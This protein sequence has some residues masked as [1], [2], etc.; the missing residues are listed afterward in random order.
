MTVP[1]GSSVKPRALVVVHSWH[2]GNT[3]KVAEALARVLGAEVRT[4]DRVDPESL[5][6]YDLVGF[7]AGIDSG[8]HYRPILDLADKL[9]EGAG[10]RAFIFSTCGIPAAF[11]RGEEFERQVHANHA[12]LRAKLL[13]RDYTVAGEFSCVGFNT[14]SFL[15]YFGG[16]NKGRP[17]AAD[18][19]G[20]EDFVRRLIGI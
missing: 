14:N 5:G 11:A 8:S 12:E 10:R 20:A 3:R 17:D 19:R 6:E 18:L 9:P 4:P 2:H 7:G 1:S 16:L 13:D 15:R